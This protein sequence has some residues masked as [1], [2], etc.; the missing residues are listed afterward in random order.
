MGHFLFSSD[1]TAFGWLGV[2]FGLASGLGFSVSKYRLRQAAEKTSEDLVPSDGLNDSSP[3]HTR[4]R[5]GSGSFEL[6]EAEYGQRDASSRLVG[7]RERR[8][9]D[10]V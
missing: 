6:P 2:L 7:S 1:L 3:S 4:G 5:R 8:T 9:T 10:A